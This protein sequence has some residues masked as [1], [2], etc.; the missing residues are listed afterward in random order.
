[1]DR[2][3]SALIN[4]SWRAWLSNVERLAPEKLHVTYLPGCT[5]D[6]LDFPRR[7]TLTHSDRTGELYLSI[8]TEYNRKQISGLYT[9]LMRDEV[10]AELITDEKGPEFRIYCHVSGGFVIGTAGW[11]YDIFHRELRL[12]LEA[13]RCG[14][15]ALFQHNRELDNA[16]V[17]VLFRSK[18]RRFA[19]VEDWGVMGDY[20]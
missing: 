3:T 15:N 13:L 2:C 12:V 19:K 11:R 18:D 8:G 14:D 6:D 20:R 5:P 9:R 17:K 4:P 10:I 1:M 7:Y 16:P